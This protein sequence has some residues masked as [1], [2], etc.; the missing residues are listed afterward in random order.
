MHSKI[1]AHLISPDSNFTVCTGVTIT[2]MFIFVKPWLNAAEAAWI[3][4]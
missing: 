2:E 4:H 3:G 1:A